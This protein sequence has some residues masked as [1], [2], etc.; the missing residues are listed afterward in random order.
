MVA[1]IA[2]ALADECVNAKSTR[3]TINCGALEGQSRL[4]VREVF[5][6]A[7]REAGWPEQSM[8]FDEWRQLARLAV[9][10]CTAMLNLPGGIRAKRDEK[11]VV[12]E[13]LAR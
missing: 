5:K 2:A 9:G 8:G 4:V 6:L 11:A 12:L 3:A 7:W 13:V 10:D 1:D